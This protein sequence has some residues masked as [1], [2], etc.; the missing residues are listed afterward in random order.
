MSWGSFISPRRFSVRTATIMAAVSASSP[1]LAQWYVGVDAGPT[2]Q[3]TARVGVGTDNRTEYHVGAGMQAQVGY[4]FGA[5][6]AEFELGYRENLLSKI[7]KVDPTAAGGTLATTTAMVNGVWD[8]LPASSWHPFVGVGIGAAY[9]Q[10]GGITRNQNPANGYGGFDLQFAYQGFAGIGYDITPEWEAKAQ[11]KYLGTTDYTVTAHS[12][13]SGGVE[14]GSHAVLAGFTYKFAAPPKPSVEAFANPVPVRPYR[15]SEDG[16]ALPVNEALVGKGAGE[17]TAELSADDRTVVTDTGQAVAATGAPPEAAPEGEGKDAGAA[18]TPKEPED[19]NFHA[20]YTLTEQVHPNFHSPNYSGANGNNAINNK[21]QSR[22]TQSLTPFLAARLGPSTELYVDPEMFEGFGLSAGLGMGGLTNGEAQKV[23]SKQLKVYMARYYLKQVIGFGGPQEWQEGAPHQLAGW[24]DVSRLTVIAGGFS[25]T[26]FMGA[27]SYAQD[28]RHDFDNW[29]ILQAGAW[30]WAGNGRAYTGGLYVEFNQEDWALR[31]AGVLQPK[32]PGGLAVYYHG[33]D[34][35]NLDHNVELETRYKLGDRPGKT[36]LLGFLNQG[37]MGSYSRINSLVD[38]GVDIGKATALSRSDW[39][40][41]KVGYA[42]NLEQEV[43]DELGVFARWSWNNGA[44]E[45][46]N[47]ADIDHSLS[48]G[49][50][51]KGGRWGRPDDT[52]GLGMATNGLSGAHQRFLAN[53]G[54]GMMLGEGSLPKYQAEMSLESYY[55]WKVFDPLTL[56]ADYQF[57]NNP[58]YNPTRGPVHFFGARL[59]A[60]Y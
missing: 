53:G 6:K 60:E 32:T 15:Q 37:N 40:K 8:F 35:D 41:S 25:L 24:Q 43:A 16:A 54:Q 42:V 11:Y 50:S 34:A 45:N 20:Q 28:A 2:F 18:E 10:A 47:Y 46:W 33:D 22:E 3:N 21:F 26:D 4:D 30:D 57:M 17:Q 39:G 12:D 14:F 1:A 44:T 19:W 56:T 23:G 13:G 55:A 49:I 51:L 52:Y 5:P 38:Q 7:G 31:W 29:A 48:G 36:R 9:I 59:H 58:G 27:N